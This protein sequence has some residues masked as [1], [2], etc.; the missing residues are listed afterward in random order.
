MDTAQWPQGIGLVKPMEELIAVNSNTNSTNRSNNMNN[1]TIT[2][3]AATP[4]TPATP[5]TTATGSQVMVE[6]KT[7]PQKEQ[8]LNCPR[9]NSI[10]TKFCYYNNYSLT[11]PRYFCK[12]CRRYWTEGG[13]LRNVP[14]GGGS[15][16]NK[17]TTSSCTTTTTSTITT[18]TAT[19]TTTSATLPSIRGQDLNLAFPNPRNSMGEYGEM[20][21][22]ESSG[23]NGS[24]CSVVASSSSLSAM[25]LLRSGMVVRG[26]SSSSPFVSMNDAGMM[27]YPAG[28]GL[29]EFKPPASLSFNPHDPVQEN[30]GRLLFP[31]EDLR[32][33]DE[34]NRGG[35]GGDA[36]GFW[37]GMMGGGGG[38]GGG[39]TG[40]GPW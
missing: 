34:S 5:A 40:A 33:V 6:R 10:N 25:E 12:T 11:Q 16:K 24:G 2:R 1:N 21:S 27:P 35:H 4:A 19:T 14:V 39:G 13:S 26:L 8:A 15:R 17:R 37:T 28:F 20:A 9:C 7:R 31:F 18:A 23:N 30:A 32:Q 36:Q 29:H 3:T 22:M 38:G